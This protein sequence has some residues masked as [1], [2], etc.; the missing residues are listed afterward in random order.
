MRNLTEENLTDAVLASL[1]ACGDARLKDVMTSLFRHLHAF[2]RE[3]EPTPE[4]WFAGIRFLTET[5]KMCD[6]KRQEFILLS[7]TWG[8]SMLVDAINNRKQ[9]GATESSVLGPF[10]VDGAPEKNTGADLAPD[11]GPGV[12]VRGKV[13][14]PDGRPLANATLDV[15]QTA[16]NGLYHMQDAG[17][18]EYH[19]CGKVRTAADG[20]YRFRTLKPVSYSIPTDGTVG[21]WLGWV[22]RHPYRPAHIHFIVSAPGCRPVV[23]QLFTEGDAYLESDAVFAVKNSL[24]VKYEPAGGEWTVDH[25]FVL[26]PAVA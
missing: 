20:S 5:G 3:I 21:K 10:Y 26:E 11:E 4:E 9:A 13:R 16:P 14:T 15:W 7:D 24:V 17:Q 8:V 18:D 19:L 25:D 23:T 2:V 6:D 1:A 12:T 22:G